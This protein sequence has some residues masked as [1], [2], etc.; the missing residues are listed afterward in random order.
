[1]GR[2]RAL[3]DKQRQAVALRFLAD[4][5]HAEIAEAMG[6][7]EPAARRNV[8]E[9]LSGCAGTDQFTSPPAV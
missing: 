1:M 9:G 3:P 6:T 7:S 2:V 4:L 5:S 8:F